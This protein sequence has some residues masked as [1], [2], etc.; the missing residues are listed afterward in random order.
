MYYVDPIIKNLLEQINRKAE[1]IIFDWIRMKTQT[2]F[3]SGY[4]MK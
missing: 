4:L 2:V 3:R 1:E